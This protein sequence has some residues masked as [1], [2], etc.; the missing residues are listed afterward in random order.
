VTW[1]KICGVT[2]PG[3]AERAIELGASAVGLI[4]APSRRQ[5]S[6]AQAREIARVVRGRAEL[7][8]VFKE[9]AS[10]PAVHAAIGFDR[11]QIHGPK[12]PE[13]R[14]PVRVLRAVRPEDLER[15]PP[16]RDGEMI[17][18]DGSQG[19]GKAFDWALAASVPRPFVLAGGLR[20][21]N[22]GFAIAAARPFGVDVASGVEAEPGIKDIE[23]L[24]RFFAAVKEADRGR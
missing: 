2:T 23:K 20:P 15:L 24:R 9:T 11:L 21:E 18:I 14:P 12:D 7:V 1:I 4:F 5:V 19:Q 13:P 6:T 17:L 10:I 16:A 22:V 8:G 3:D